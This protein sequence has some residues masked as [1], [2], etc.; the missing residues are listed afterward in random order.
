MGRY[1]TSVGWPSPGIINDSLAVWRKATR[2]AG[3]GL[4]IH[5]SG[6]GTARP[7]PSTDWA[8]I[9][10][11]GKRDPNATSLFGPYVDELLIPQ[12]KEVTA[13]YDL[14]G[15]WAD[16]ECWAAQLDYSPRALAA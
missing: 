10:P 9:G 7:S 8:R 14:D 16:G 1:P 6:V 11:D 2:D 3:V 12:L 13:K 15:V 5:Y 4:F